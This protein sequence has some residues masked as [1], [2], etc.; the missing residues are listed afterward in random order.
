[1]V[2]EAGMQ[3]FSRCPALTHKDT[4][5]DVAPIGWRDVLQYRS[6]AA[7]VIRYLFLL[8]SRLLLLLFIYFFIEQTHWSANNKRRKGVAG[9]LLAGG[10]KLLSRYA[11]RPA[12]AVDSRWA[13]FPS[14]GQPLQI[15]GLEG[16]VRGSCSCRCARQ[17]TS[18]EGGLALELQRRPASS[19]VPAVPVNQ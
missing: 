15:R 16:C 19:S 6:T 10:L 11:V 18:Q 7:R 13:G 1:M 2:L 17:G 9:F 8:V 12:E 4:A 3:A 14:A 5:R